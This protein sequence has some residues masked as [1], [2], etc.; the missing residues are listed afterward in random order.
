M[1]PRLEEFRNGDLRFPARD[2]G[3]RDGIPVLLLH[4]WPQDG[5]S[6]DAVTALLHDEGYRTFAP[7]LRGVSTHANPRSR[8][9]FRASRLRSDVAAMVDQIGG[10]VHLVGHD[11]GAAL[12]WDVATHQPE[13]LLSL[14]SVS[15]PHP[16]A[17]LRSLVTSRQGL[18]SWYMYY[19]QLP[20]LPELT[21]G[22]STVMARALTA[23]GQSGEAARRDA[24][25]NGRWAARR[26]G[27]HWYRGAL[28]EPF[29]AGTPTPVPVLQVWS[30][31]DKAVLRAGIDLTREHAAGHYRL[32]VLEGVSHWIPDEVPDALVA[33][34]LVHFDHAWEVAR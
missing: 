31:G 23:T 19:F 1:T 28:F 12:A 33:E 11:W 13:L 27:F 17:F 4:G 3:P 7:D 16:A 32:H 29:D 14:T 25:R 9:A 5:S 34:L 22:W 21:L 15:V 24:H 10:P 30:D 8:R 2:S 26:G 18:A 20:W 6:W